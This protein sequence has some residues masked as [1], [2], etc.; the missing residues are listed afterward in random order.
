[1]ISTRDLSL[2]PDIPSFRRLTRA[3]AMLDAIMSPEWEF[4]Y[5]S[6]DSHWAPGET[7]ASMR[8]GS[9]DLWHALLSSSGVALHGL[10]HEAPNF[11]PDRPWPGIFDALPSEFQANFLHEPAFDTANS[12]FCVW[13]RVTDDRW[14][15]GPVQLPPGEYGDGSSDLLSILAGN[16]SQYVELASEYYERQIAIADVAAIYRHEPVTEELVRRLN[17][18][19]DLE[20]LAKDV[21]E[22]GYPDEGWR[23]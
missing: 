4:R 21:A 6:F 2:L 7:M 15:R 12:T 9:G 17:P 18:E 10:A 13:R 14:S 16:P 8:N 19:V 5:Y 20:S 1:V 22:I 11:R 23:F 3:L